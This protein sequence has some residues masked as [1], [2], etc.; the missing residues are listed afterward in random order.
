[1]KISEIKAATT[2]KLSAVSIKAK[3]AI[4]A[5]SVVT[6][7][8]GTAIIIK[9]K[10]PEETL[11]MKVDVCEEIMARRWD[12]RQRPSEIEIK[13]CMKIFDENYQAE[14]IKNRAKRANKSNN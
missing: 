14:K 4:V 13:D 7:T 5:V 10:P 1:M 12:K 6:A 9:D 8:A 11:S 2:A 3:I